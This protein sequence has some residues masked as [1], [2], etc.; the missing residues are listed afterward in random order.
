MVSGW[1][2]QNEP[3]DQALSNTF[4]STSSQSVKLHNYKESKDV[5]RIDVSGISKF[6]AARN[7]VGMTGKQIMLWRTLA[8]GSKYG[9][10]VFSLL[11]T[12]KQQIGWVSEKNSNPFLKI[13]QACLC[14]NVLQTKIEE[15]SC[16]CLKSHKITATLGPRVGLQSLA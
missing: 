2:V 4:Q 12:G 7:V 1:T 5:L 13:E 9:I 8:Y 6:P 15:A 16:N 14:L 10:G 3:S 11:E